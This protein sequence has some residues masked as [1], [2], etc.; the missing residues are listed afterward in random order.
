MTEQKEQQI[1]FSIVEGEPF[2]SHDMSINFNPSQ[3]I[4]DFRC[5]TPR[6]DPRTN[7]GSRVMQLKHNIVMLEPYH[8]K[9]VAEVLAGM[10]QKY[11]KRFGKIEKSK[12]IK[13]MEKETRKEKPKLK[14]ENSGNEGKTGEFPRYLG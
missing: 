10:V 6:I 12:A 4:F 1:K 9:Q 13:Q 3:F 8:A 7:D 11:E 5:V 2:F 14:S